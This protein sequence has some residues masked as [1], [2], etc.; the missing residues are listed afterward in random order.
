MSRQRHDPIAL[1]ADKSDRLACGGRL[2][3]CTI[4][5]VLLPVPLSWDGPALLVLRGAW[6]VTNG[7]L[8]D[9]TGKTKT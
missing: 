2:N 3:V 6:C 1:I 7:L 9:G 5:F 4:D 8:N